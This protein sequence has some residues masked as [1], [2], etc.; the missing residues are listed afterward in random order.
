MPQ[1]FRIAIRP[2]GLEGVLFEESFEQS[3]IWSGLRKSDSHL[4]NN[5]LIGWEGSL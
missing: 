3:E 2:A 1:S 4:R 5:G